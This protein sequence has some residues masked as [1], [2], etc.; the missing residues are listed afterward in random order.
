MTTINTIHRHN[1]HGLKQQDCN[2]LASAK[3]LHSVVINWLILFSALF[4]L[5]ASN[6]NADM[7]FDFQKKMADKGNAEAQFKVGEMYQT[8][9]G[10]KKDTAAASEWFKKAQSN[11]HTEAG[12]RLL[13]LRIQK[14]GLTAE[15]KVAAK[16]ISTKAKSGDGISQYYLGMMYHHGVGLT[17]NYDKALQ[18]YK[19]AEL[20]GVTAAEQGRLDVQTAKNKAAAVASKRAAE[21]K[22]KAALEKKKKAQQAAKAKAEAAKNKASQNQAEAEQAAARAA[23]AKA[24]AAEKE[25][26]RQALI[27]ARQ[28]RAKAQQAA[29]KKEEAEKAEFEADPCSGKSARFLSTCR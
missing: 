13:Y 25:K 29:T 2:Q 22:K 18:W 16:E 8:G 12:Y 23:K 3:R 9:R 4:L 1:S 15:N 14:Q 11:G 20:K 10:V 21:A 26:K 17:K 19:K 5:T 28:D 7:V 6:A 27:K 24:V